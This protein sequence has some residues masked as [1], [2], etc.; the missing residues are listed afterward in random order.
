MQLYFKTICT[1]VSNDRLARGY[2]PR[3]GKRFVGTGSCARRGVRAGGLDR[4]LK[5]IRCGVQAGGLDRN[6][7]CVCC[8]V[9]AG[10]LDHNLCDAAAA[11][12][13]LQVLPLET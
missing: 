8:G 9:Q 7:K 11:F 4:N 13:S 2:R 3:P 1:H 6:L 10:G 12:F 5:C